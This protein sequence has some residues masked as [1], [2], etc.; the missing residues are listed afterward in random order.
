MISLS[1]LLPHEKGKGEGNR[2]DVDGRGCLREK[3]QDWAVGEQERGSKEG[4]EEGRTQREREREVGEIS[5]R[6]RGYVVVG[7]PSGWQ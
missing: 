7:Y 2:D 4:A 1:R 3:E 5:S 6:G